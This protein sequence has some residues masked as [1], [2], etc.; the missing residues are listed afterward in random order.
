MLTTCASAAESENRRALAILRAKV[1]ATDFR[2]R[3]VLVNLATV[4]DAEDDPAGLHEAEGLLREV[5]ATNRTSPPP[6]PWD[7]AKAEGELG[8][9]LLEQG[10]YAAAEPLLVGSFTTLRDKLGINDRAR[11][12]KALDWIIELYRREGEPAKAAPFLAIRTARRAA[13]GPE[14]RTDAG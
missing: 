13:A 3:F 2:T 9:C 10:K 1:P 12:D 14:R 5:V 6:D 7:A 8:G 4:L 11:V